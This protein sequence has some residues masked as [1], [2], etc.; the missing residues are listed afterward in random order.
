MRTPWGPFPKPCAHG[1]GQWGQEVYG[2]GPCMLDSSQ[3]SQ[4][5]CDL[6][7]LNPTPDR[8]G[9]RQVADGG[10]GAPDPANHYVI[11]WCSYFPLYPQHSEQDP[12]R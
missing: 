2:Q 1:E 4:L 8:L 5:C 11:F 12:R 3:A 6:A 7:A 9:G 10:A